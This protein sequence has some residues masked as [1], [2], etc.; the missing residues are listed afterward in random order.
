MRLGLRTGLV[1]VEHDHRGFFGIGLGILPALHRRAHELDHLLLE[2]RIGKVLFQ[3]VD[4]VFQRRDALVLILEGHQ[5]VLADTRIQNLAVFV[6]GHG[7]NAVRLPLQQRI[8]V[9]ALLQNRHAI[10]AAIRR[11]ALLGHPRQERVLVTE[12]PDADRLA[13]EVLRAGDAGVLPAGQHQSRRL[14]RLRDVDDRQTL[15]ACRQGGR[16]PVQHGIGATACQHLWRCDVWPAGQ[17]RHVQPFFLV[18]ALLQRHVIACELCLR[19]P[20]QLQRDFVVGMGI[21]HRRACT[22]S[23][24]HGACDQMFHGNLPIGWF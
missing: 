13:L 7:R 2:G 24:R 19:D 15:F 5:F 8:D 23:Q 20:L 18:I 1:I 17:D 21:G 9:E 12:E 14:E 6:I 16:H 3:N 11:N 4:P 10:L 22:Q